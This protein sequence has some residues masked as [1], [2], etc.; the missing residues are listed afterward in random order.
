MENTRASLLT[1]VPSAA[2]T[3]SGIGSAVEVGE[4]I[5]L[6]VTLNITAMSGTS[7]SVEVYLE[8]S[9]DDG[10]TWYTLPNGNFTSATSVGQ[11]VMQITAPFGN[12]LRAVYT[13]GGTTPSV[14]FAVKAVAKG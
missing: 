9:D 1:L 7:P 5:Q 8:T 14:T 11:Q 2:Q 3:S 4:Y 13:L 10:T 12:Y 6:L